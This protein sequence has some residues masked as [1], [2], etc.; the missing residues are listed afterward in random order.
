MIRAL[1]GGCRT[2]HPSTYRMSRPNGLPN[3]ILLIIRSHGEFLINGRHFT[4]SPGYAVIFA[5]NTGYFYGNPDGDYIDDWLHFDV[6]DSPELQKGL[7]SMSNE[8]FPIDNRELFTFCIQHILIETSY[9]SS[10]SAQDNINAL[11]TLLFNHLTASFRERNNPKTANPLRYQLQLLRLNMENSLPEEHSIRKHA[12]QLQISESYFQFLYK[13]LF[14]I[15]FQQDLIQMRVEHAKLI[16][17]TS[18]LPLDKVSEIC[19]YTNE[20][21]FY[22]QFKKLTGTSPAKFRKSADEAL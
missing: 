22:R 12:Q 15:S 3:Y 19:G 6:A 16:L 18:N 4:V 9:N 17:T 7:L 21:H 8:P 14:G 20:V 10:A 11:F 13:S 5:P 1:T 2:Y